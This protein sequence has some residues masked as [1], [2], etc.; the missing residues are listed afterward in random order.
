[1]RRRPGAGAGRRLPR[2]ELLLERDE[3]PDREVAHRGVEPRLEERL[4]A[5]VLRRVHPDEH[6]ADELQRVGDFVP[7]TVVDE[8]VVITHAQDGELRAFYNVCLH[9][10]GAVARGKGN[11]KTLQCSYHGWTYA[12]DG[13]LLKAREF[14]GVEDWSEAD[15]CLPRV[16]VETWGPLVFVNLDENPIPLPEMMGAIPGEVAAA[17]FD[18][19][20]YFVVDS[21]S[22]IPYYGYYT[23]DA[24]DARANIYVE[25][26][27][28]SPEVREISEIS[29]VVRGMR[30]YRIQR[31]CFPAEA[32]ESV[33]GGTLSGGL[34]R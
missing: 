34:Q 30:G 33:R 11:R 18:A 26:G 28:P 20:Y 6:R 27:G 4:Q 21:A 7:V 17:G 10:A 22:D 5:I 15:F 3:G 14:D 8:P 13:R 12:L 32:T 19:E 1:M 25:T 29:Q 23:P 16:D 24:S 2:F 31:L 9:R